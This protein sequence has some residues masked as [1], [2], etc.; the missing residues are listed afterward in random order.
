MKAARGMAIQQ[1]NTISSFA[2]QSLLSVEALALLT[3]IHHVD[4]LGASFLVPGALLLSLPLI[5]MWWFLRAYSNVARW[6]YVIFVIFLILGFG[7]Y[8]GLWNHTIKMMVFF[9]R[10][11][12]TASMAGLPFPPVGSVFHEVTG[13]LTLVAAVVAA[14]FAWQ[15]ATTTRQQPELPAQRRARNS[16]M[17]R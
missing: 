1:H 9:A 6:S 14:Y 3:S 2:R 11:A 4:E 8:D 12:D 7:L 10:G 13:V 17:P 15:F 16:W 5:F